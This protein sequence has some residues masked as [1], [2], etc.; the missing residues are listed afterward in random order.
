MLPTRVAGPQKYEVVGMQDSKRKRSGAE[1]GPVAA[2]GNNVE[3]PDS[4]V[5]DSAALERLQASG[6]YSKDFIHLVNSGRAAAALAWAEDQWQAAEAFA[7]LDGA[8][9]VQHGNQ[10]VKVKTMDAIEYVAGSMQEYKD[11][12]SGIEGL[13]PADLYPTFATC[14]LQLT[15]RVVQNSID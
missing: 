9:D 8:A 5:Q 14:A 7:L 6:A 12:L 11:A 1:A 3:E 4:P 2:A 13:V 10:A 15:C